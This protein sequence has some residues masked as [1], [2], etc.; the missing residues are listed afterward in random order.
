M[1]EFKRTDRPTSSPWGGVQGGD[2]LAPGI[3]M[4]HTAGHGGIKLS[5][6]RN[7]LVPDYMRAEGGWYEEDCDWAIVAV[8]FP[9][10]F[11]KLRPWQEPGA[12][13]WH[14]H[15]I[16][17]MQHWH[18]G[19]YARFV[20]DRK[21]PATTFKAAD[22]ALHNMLGSVKPIPSIMCRRGR[23]QIIEELWPILRRAES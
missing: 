10:P 15:A 9:E 20:A 5:A 2:E 3:W 11:Q 16:E 22:E 12:K 1:K 18:A 19:D 6:E 13:T 4:V 17:S 23:E 21:I 14:Q 7:R 8:V